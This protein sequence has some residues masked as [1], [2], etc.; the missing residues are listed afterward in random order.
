MPV[1]VPH[2]LAQLSEG[3]KMR[4]DREKRLH[5]HGGETFCTAFA[6]MSTHWDYR[7]FQPECQAL[8][9]VI[10]MVPSTI[11]FSPESK[12]YL[13]ISNDPPFRPVHDPGSVLSSSPLSV[14]GYGVVQAYLKP[15]LCS[16]D[17]ISKLIR[18]LFKRKKEKSQGPLDFLL[19]NHRLS[20]ALAFFLFYFFCLVTELPL[21][22]L[23]LHTYPWL[24]PLAAIA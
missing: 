10:K 18:G 4:V 13:I 11:E 17:M 16:D 24:L 7:P 5:G 21:Q 23:H 20:F 15:I 22:L 14:C 6:L 19:G 8:K 12:L 9:A 1:P 2:N 3:S